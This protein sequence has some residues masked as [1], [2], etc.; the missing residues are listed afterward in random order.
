MSEVMYD[1]NSLLISVMLFVSMLLAIEAGYRLGRRAEKRTD[2]SSR[3]HVGAIQASLLGVLALLLGFTF[4]LSLQRFDNRSEA[5]VDESNAIGTA[6]LRAQL[7]HDTMRGEVMTLLRR[8]VDLRVQAG[9]IALD[10][11][12]Q[13]ETVIAKTNKVLDDLW[14]YARRAAGEDGRAVMAG[15]FIQSLNEL[16]DSYGRRDAALTRHVPELVL[17]L[18]Y[19]TFLMTGGVVGYAAGVSGHRVSIVTYILVILIVVLTFII[20]DLDRPR[21]GLI[22]VS[23]NSLIELGTAI[24]IAQSAGTPGAVPEDAPRPAVTGRR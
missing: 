23:Q 21:R 4:S 20:I 5:V 16:I 1:Q 12:A 3:A 15:L 10:E 2:E 8:Y 7:L 18:L 22:R 9:S 24:D 6:Y 14:G 13:R 19:G 17:F 11:E